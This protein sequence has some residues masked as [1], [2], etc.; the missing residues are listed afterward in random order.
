LEAYLRHQASL[1]ASNDPEDTLGYAKAVQESVEAEQQ[2]CLSS[3]DEYIKWWSAYE[4][5]TVIDVANSD[6][7]AASANAA[8]DSAWLH[9]SYFWTRVA[10]TTVETAVMRLTAGHVVFRFIR[11]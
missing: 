10:T 7:P 9:S 3:D 2:R 8:S 1:C 11:I 5:C 6:G 4:S